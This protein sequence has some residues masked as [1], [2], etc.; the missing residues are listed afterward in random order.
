M[1]CI[2]FG[3]WFGCSTVVLVVFSYFIMHAEAIA[4]IIARYHFYTF[5]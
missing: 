3:K 1:S 4:S 5:M 2:G